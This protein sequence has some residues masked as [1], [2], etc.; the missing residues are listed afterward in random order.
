[1]RTIFNVERAELAKF[2]HVR[3]RDIEDWEKGLAEPSHDAV[4]LMAAH[5]DILRS[6]LV[7]PGGM[8][9]VVRTPNLQRPDVG[10]QT[11]P[12]ITMFVTIYQLLNGLGRDRILELMSTL[13]F[14]PR[15]NNSVKTSP[16]VQEVTGGKLPF[17][18]L[19][20]FEKYLYSQSGQ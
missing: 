5:F 20:D 15:F 19:Y 2:A 9:I 12:E 17:A 4:A 7:E 8:D 3:E 18:D 11:T 16:S 1:L 14:D 6:C 10:G 13:L